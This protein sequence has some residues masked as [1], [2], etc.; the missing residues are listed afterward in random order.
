MANSTSHAALPYPI[1]NA[2]YSLEISFRVAAG[3]PTDPGT[4]DT[5][6]SSDGG[7]T[8]A[9]ITE[10]ITT[11]GTNGIGYVTL[12]GAETNNN[13][14]ALAAKSANC[15]TTPVT[16]YPRV[17]A[18]VGSGTLSAG[19]AG[20]GTLGTVLAYDVTG[21]FI[22][23]TGGTGG[24]GTGG[25]NNQARKMVTYTPSTGAFTVTP[26]WETTPDNTTTYDVLL[27]EGVTLGMLKALNPTTAGRT[28]DVS[29]GGEAGLDW[30]NVGSPATTLALTG[31]TIAVTQKVDVDTIKT[32]PVVN[33]GTITFPANSTLAS[34]INIVQIAQITGDVL[35]NLGGNVE[36]NV[37]GNVSGNVSGNVVGSV[38]NVVGLTVGD[39]AAIKA[40]TDNLPSD[41]ADQSL[42]IAAT[43]AVMNRIGAPVTASISA[44]IA[45]VKAKTDL[46]NTATFWLGA[47]AT[48]SGSTYAGAVAGS[49]VKEIAD[50]AVGSGVIGPGSIEFTVTINDDMAAPLDGAEVW[51]STD[52]AGTNVIAGTLNTN[53][54]G[55][56]TFLLDAGDYF[57]WVVHS[58]YNR[59][60]PTAITVS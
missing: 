6:L 34:T 42:I 36:G 28:L 23:T 8:F 59:D 57:L 1:R 38:G 21:C 15:V 16:L 37:D 27:P 60:N 5:E 55:Q 56:A 53:A 10:E 4:P 54:S 58:G 52:S 33:S 12:T 11:G 44:D 17:L 7:A 13:M 22:R 30:A 48:N 35:G 24:G 18:I 25:A 49:V 14:I 3:T 45:T 39:V 51:V 20:G 31:T 29:T 9:D 26:N 41:P 19:S 2:R 47:F 32:N 50:N 40:K 46:I 43:D